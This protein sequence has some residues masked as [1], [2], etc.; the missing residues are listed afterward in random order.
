MGIISAV[1]CSIVVIVILATVLKYQVGPKSAINND[2][3]MEDQCS[4]GHQD[5]MQEDILH[6]DLLRYMEELGVVKSQ[7]TRLEGYIQHVDNLDVDARDY[8][9]QKKSGI[10]YYVRVEKFIPDPYIDYE[11]HLYETSD[12]FFTVVIQNFTYDPQTDR[13]KMGFDPCSL[14]YGIKRIYHFTAT[15]GDLEMDGS[16]A[17]SENDNRSIQ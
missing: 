3:V 10:Y 7:D 15:G 13:T 17:F 16:W 9:Y 8:L 6:E 5:Q 1:V 2:Q 11:G 12:V 4:E 14:G